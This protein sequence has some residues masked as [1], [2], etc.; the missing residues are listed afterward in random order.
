VL[1]LEAAFVMTDLTAAVE[2][3]RY[4]TERLRRSVSD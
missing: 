3:I 4:E 2:R 1:R